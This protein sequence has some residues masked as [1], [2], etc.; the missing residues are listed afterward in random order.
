MEKA[1]KSR[2]WDRFV[3]L[4]RRHGVPERTLR[5]YVLRLEQYIH[6]HSGQPLRRHG[7]DEEKG[8]GVVI[9]KP[10]RPLFPIARNPS[11]TYDSRTFRLHAWWA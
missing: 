1:Q 11:H 4:A 5:W 10:L 8:A 7:P 6:T 9:F 3:I 2:F